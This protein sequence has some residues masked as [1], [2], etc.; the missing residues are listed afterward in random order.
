MSPDNEF[1]VLRL[2]DLPTNLSWFSLKMLYLKPR[3][4][5]FLEAKSK[6]NSSG[7]KYW[8]EPFELHHYVVRLSGQNVRL[9]FPS[10]VNIGIKRFDRLRA[11]NQ[12]TLV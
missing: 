7:C 11:V 12:I 5:K 8:W 6:P 4:I 1:L 2:E 10:S 3:Q 9:V